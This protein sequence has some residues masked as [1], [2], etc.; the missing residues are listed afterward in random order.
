MD[1]K[2]QDGFEELLK[3]ARDEEVKRRQKKTFKR[4]WNLLGALM[5]INIMPFSIYY[6]LRGN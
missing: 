5:F 1:K 4:L 2:D 3:E 6:L